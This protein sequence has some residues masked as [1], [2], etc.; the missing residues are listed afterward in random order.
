MFLNTEIDLTTINKDRF[1]ARTSH[2]GKY[3]Q[4]ILNLITR[5]NNLVRLIS[6]WLTHFPLRILG[7][8]CGWIFIHD[9]LKNLVG[10]LYTA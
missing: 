8:D 9:V 5:L 2:A 4:R 6:S 1:S 3:L 7:P 10:L